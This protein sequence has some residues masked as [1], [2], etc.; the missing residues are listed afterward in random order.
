MKRI[1]VTG[2]AGF[3][4]SNLCERLAKDPNN[5]V[6]SLDNYSTGSKSNHVPG[7]TYIEGETADIAKLIDFAPDAMI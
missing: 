3:I 1:L 5:Q 4:G 2:G 7:V 6:Y